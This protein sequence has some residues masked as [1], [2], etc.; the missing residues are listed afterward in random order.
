MIDFGNLAVEKCLLEPLATI[1]CPRAVEMLRDDTVYAI[2]AED[3][4]SRL[5]RARLQE[6]VASLQKSLADLR[7]LRRYNW[8][9]E[10][11]QYDVVS[12]LADC[13]HNSF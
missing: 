12:M 13:I 3:E 9:G 11:Y 2:A 10:F 1:F 4:S 6:K 8:S 7:R 5:E